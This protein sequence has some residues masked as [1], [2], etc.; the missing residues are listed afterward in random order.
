MK[1]LVLAANYPNN[2]GGISLYYIHTRNMY[3]KKQGIDV[4]VIS[5]ATSRSY[6]IDGINVLS[7]D[8][9]KKRK[10]YDYDLLVLH[11]ANL[12]NHYLFLKRFGKKFNKHVF[13][14]HGH[15]VLMCSKVY[16]KPFAY[17][18]QEHKILG[19]DVYDRI[20][21][22]VWHRYFKK[23]NDKNYYIFVSKWM[24]DEFKKWVKID[25]RMIKNNSQIIYNSGGE[26]FIKQHYN[27]K[28]NKKYDYITVRGNLDGS[29]YCVDL[30]NKLA[31]KN[32][33][34]KFL[35][36][37]KGRYF[38][39]NKRSD[40]VEWLDENVQ[41]EDIIRYMNKAKCALMLTRTDAQ[42]LMACE[43]A[44][45]GIPLITSDIPVCHEIFDDFKNVGYIKN[46]LSKNNLEDIYKR[47]VKGANQAPNKYHLDVTG[48]D[49]IA[50]FERILKK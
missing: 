38:T 2:D 6:K 45:F 41:H 25:E 46:D 43:M 36:I 1:I 21:L 47:I 29:K 23:T 8:D 28:T 40:N 34:Q 13:F 48:G 14:F 33:S 49:E 31:R 22:L 20:K 7:Y 9:F 26:E 35:I 44:S 15:E 30:V 39:Y 37:G 12:R 10:D 5:F 32:P 3:Y 4:D 24:K 50:F 17:T 18:Q 11:A 27:T 42:G 19:K 16:S